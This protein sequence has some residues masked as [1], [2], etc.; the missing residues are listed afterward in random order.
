MIMKLGQL[1]FFLGK[2]S[3]FSN[4]ILSFSRDGIQNLTLYQTIK[5]YYINV[6][7]HMYKNLFTYYFQKQSYISVCYTLMYLFIEV[8]KL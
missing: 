1:P 4:T 6:S 3:I 5:K 2:E 7:F 8:Y